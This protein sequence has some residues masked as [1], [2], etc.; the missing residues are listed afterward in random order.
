M[1]NY[2]KIKISLVVLKVNQRKIL[3]PISIEDKVS[4][5]NKYSLLATTNHSGTL[6]RGHYCA[7]IKNIHSSSWYSC[8]YKLVFDEEENYVKNTTSYIVFYWKV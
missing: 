8:N 3:A 5:A 7:F 6:N 2:L 4:F 1:V